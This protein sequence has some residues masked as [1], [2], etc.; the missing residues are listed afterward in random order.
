[1][2]TERRQ[3]AQ[4]LLEDLSAPSDKVRE[5]VNVL[6]AVDVA[7]DDLQYAYLNLLAV[8]GDR[9][10]ATQVFDIA[11]HCIRGQ[12]LRGWEFC[13]FLESLPGI[14]RA[15]STEEEY[16]H[17]LWNFDDLDMSVPLEL[18]N[19]GAGLIICGFHVGAYRFLTTELRSE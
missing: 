7:E 10:E 17:V 5:A 3:F 8:F 19:R 9:L 4:K 11:L 13:A 14:A 2:T 16:Q 6:D 1:M 18:L 15:G 12:L